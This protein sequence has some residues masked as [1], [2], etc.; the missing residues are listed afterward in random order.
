MPERCS[1]WPVFSR[2]SMAGF[3]CSPRQQGTTVATDAT[4]I[5]VHDLCCIPVSD[6]YGDFDKSEDIAL[7]QS[8][9]EFGAHVDAAVSQRSSVTPTSVS[10]HLFADASAES[11]GTND[12]GYPPLASA[13]MSSS[14]WLLFNIT[15]PGMYRFSATGNV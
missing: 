3:G 6:C 13:S 5:S 11:H 4:K 12:D 2:P 7:K 8:Q 10:V 14:F 15:T 9:S 1:R